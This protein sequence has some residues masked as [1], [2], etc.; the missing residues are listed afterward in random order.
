MFKLHQKNPD[1]SL[2]D[3]ALTFLLL[4]VILL[5]CLM[6]ITAPSAAAGDDESETIENE[7][8]ELTADNISYDYEAGLIS[9]RGDVFFAR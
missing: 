4:L 3:N 1:N 9:A 7:Y 2:S 6:F 8:Y 5:T